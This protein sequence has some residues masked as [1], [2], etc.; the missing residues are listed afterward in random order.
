MSS[1]DINTHG[2]V[3][4]KYPGVL[5]ILCCGVSFVVTGQGMKY[6]S[7]SSCLLGLAR[8]D[9]SS[10]VSAVESSSGDA[11]IGSELDGDVVAFPWCVVVVN[12]AVIESLA[13]NQRAV[14][15]TFSVGSSFDLVVARY[16]WV[17]PQIRSND[18]FSATVRLTFIFGRAPFNYRVIFMHRGAYLL[19]TS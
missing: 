7:W 6:S 10:G 15:R 5:S 16:R 12:R 1:L 17:T 9:S 19:G 13:L 4:C 2:Y 11:G 14:L 8:G 3:S 18:C